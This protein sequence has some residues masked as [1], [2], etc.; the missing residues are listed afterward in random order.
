PAEPML[1]SRFP[2][3]FTRAGASPCSRAGPFSPPCGA[4]LVRQYRSQSGDQGDQTGVHEVVDHL[5][6][7]LVGR[8]SLFVEQAAIAANNAASEPG[9]KQLRRPETFPDPNPAL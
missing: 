5:F 4:R 2:L 6:D 8:R 9:L 3:P 1:N 7:V